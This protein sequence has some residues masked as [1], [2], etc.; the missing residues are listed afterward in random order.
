M[1]HSCT[2]TLTILQSHFIFSLYI[3]I[4][5]YLSGWN[6]YMYEEIFFAD[7]TFVHCFVVCWSYNYRPYLCFLFLIRITTIDS[8]LLFLFSCIN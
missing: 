3:Y 8:H 2:C 7:L 4:F 6:T 5:M 1:F